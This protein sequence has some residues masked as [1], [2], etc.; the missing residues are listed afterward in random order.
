MSTRPTKLYLIGQE[1]AKG[2]LTIVSEKEIPENEKGNL[3]YE[4]ANNAAAAAGEKDD[5]EADMTCHL[6]F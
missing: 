5:V 1:Q 4:R 2:F 3:L 6:K